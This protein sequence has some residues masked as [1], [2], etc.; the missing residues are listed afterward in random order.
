MKRAML[1]YFSQRRMIRQLTD[2]KLS[3][4]IPEKS[5]QAGTG[6]GRLYP[7]SLAIT[8]QIINT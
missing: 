6:W 3:R 8:T 7:D 1:K 5:G 2:G 4:Q